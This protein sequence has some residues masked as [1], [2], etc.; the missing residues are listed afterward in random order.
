[1]LSRS[2]LYPLDKFWIWLILYLP[3]IDNSKIQFSLGLF[4]VAESAAIIYLFFA[5][6]F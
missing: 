6:V 2:R 4:P 5:V 3:E 1:M